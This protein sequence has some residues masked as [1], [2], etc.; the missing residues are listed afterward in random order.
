LDL[1]DNAVVFRVDERSRIQAL[2]RTAPML[3][4]RPGLPALHPRLCPARHHPLF[5]ALEVAA[6]DVTADASR[7][8]KD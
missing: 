7:C 3:P 8:V 2:D 6:G 5:A 1:P 4:L